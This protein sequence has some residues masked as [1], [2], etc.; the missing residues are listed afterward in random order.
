MTTLSLRLPESV[1]Q[2]LVKWAR[3][4]HK[5][6]SSAARELME[7][8]WRFVLLE[9][10]RDGK[11]SL[12]ALAQELGSSVSETMDLLAQ[13]GLSARVGYDDY[14]QSLKHVKRVWRPGG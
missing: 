14:L 7:C 9:A 6:K 4:A 3:L 11:L 5:D 12:G 1:F 13:H 2:K 8:G 10:Y